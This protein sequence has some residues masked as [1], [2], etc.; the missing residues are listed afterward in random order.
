MLVGNA[1][2]NCI[3]SEHPDTTLTKSVTVRVRVRMVHSALIQALSK[4]Y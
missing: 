1:F 4:K 3:I 2:I